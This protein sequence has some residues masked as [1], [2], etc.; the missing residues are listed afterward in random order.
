M[1]DNL[2]Q[3][4]PLRTVEFADEEKG[5]ESPPSS[6]KALS[7]DGTAAESRQGDA[8]HI[9]RAWWKMDCTVLPIVTAIFF[10]CFLVCEF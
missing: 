7:Y 8:V 2:H 5:T 6:S 4:D 9:A 1:S 10:L 3:S